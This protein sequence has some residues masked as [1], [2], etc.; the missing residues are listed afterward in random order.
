MTPNR[1]SLSIGSGSGLAADFC[2]SSAE[3]AES[4]D[5]AYLKNTLPGLG[6]KNRNAISKIRLGLRSLHSLHSRVPLRA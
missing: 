1:K 2:P 6:P 3:S 4:A 5:L